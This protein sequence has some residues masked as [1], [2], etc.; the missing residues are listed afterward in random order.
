MA[1]GGGA[2][3]T[4]NKILPGTYINFISASRAVSALSDRGLAALPAALDWGEEG[5]VFPVTQKQF[6]EDAQKIFGYLYDAEQLKPIRDLFIHARTVYFYRINS[7][8]KAANTYAAAKYSGVRGNSIRIAILDSMEQENAF[9]V[10]TYLDDAQVDV[11]TVFTAEELKDNDF[12]VFKRDAEL[13]ALAGVPL[14]GGTNK[15]ELTGDDYQKALEALESYGFHVL[16]CPSED[17]LI[18]K[19]FASYTKR[20]RDECGV[21]FQ[22]V[23]HNYPGDYHGVVNLKNNVLDRDAAGNEL[24]YWTGGALAECG[25]NKTLTNQIYDGEYEVDANAKQADLIKSVES[26]EFCYHMVGDSI[27]VLED[28]NSFVSYT[29]EMNSDFALNQV[30]RVLDQYGNDI[31][32][33]FHSKYLGKI[34]NDADGRVSL[35]GDLSTYNKQMQSIRAIQNFDPKELEVTA[36]EDKRSIVVSNPVQPICAMEKCY[37]TIY[38]Q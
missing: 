27:R 33:L 31:A 34:P 10:C 6:K 21:K 11:Q 35:W 12:V 18:K 9:D 38:V 26:G 4:Q 30:V 7:G 13:K 32:G 28:I 15:E 20:L 19:L 22:T 25:V 24:V 23:I 3:T 14:T 1:L 5:R 17:E 2:F 36:G 8:V 37:M 16:I 29:E